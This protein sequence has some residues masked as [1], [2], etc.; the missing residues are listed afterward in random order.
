MGNVLQLP[1]CQIKRQDLCFKCHNFVR[2][3]WKLV[4]KH[5]KRNSNILFL[6]FPLLYPSHTKVGKIRFTT[7]TKKL[8]H[9][10]LGKKKIRIKIKR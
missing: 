2:K 7:I 6:P 3:R 1:V 10:N 9:S 4:S 5:T 8:P